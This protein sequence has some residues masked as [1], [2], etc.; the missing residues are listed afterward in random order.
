MKKALCLMIVGVIATAAGAS[1]TAEWQ[2]TTGVTNDIYNLQV[3]TNTEGLAIGGL[4]IEVSG[5]GFVHIPGVI[6][7]NTLLGT[8]TVFNMDSTKIAVATQNVSAT[9][10]SGAAVY[11]TG[12]G[13][14]GLTPILLSVVV[15]TGTISNPMAELGVTATESTTPLVRLGSG[16]GASS[17]PLDIVPEPTTMA[18]LGLGGL[19]LLRRRK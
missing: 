14:M 6:F 5:S 1:V 12:E 7:N 10:L 17:V 11:K 18:L 16:D 19:A 2:K 4:D 15:P 8:Y 9:E 3:L 13:D